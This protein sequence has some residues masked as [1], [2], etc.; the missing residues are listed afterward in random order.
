MP[1]LSQFSVSDPG[2]I[3]HSAWNMSCPQGLC[4]CPLSKRGIT[5]HRC[6]VTG[7]TRCRQRPPGR[8]SLHRPI[9]G[10]QMPRG[11]EKETKKGK[12]QRHEASRL[13]IHGRPDAFVL[14]TNETM[15][16]HHATCGFP[17]G[18]EQFSVGGPTGDRYLHTIW[19]VTTASP[20]GNEA[21]SVEENSPQGLKE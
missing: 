7:A 20:G 8:P 19:S 6:N 9:T 21:G 10:W 16:L 14:P 4:R 15:M 5:A 2:G 11:R 12:G 17:S 18:R 3:G 13:S 1:G